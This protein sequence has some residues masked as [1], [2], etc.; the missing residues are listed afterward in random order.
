MASS[1]NIIMC[2]I[3]I[4]SRG[5][6]WSAGGPADP[7]LEGSQQPDVDPDNCAGAGV[8]GSIGKKCTSG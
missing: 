2:A 8:G 4:L 3:N 1:G 6:N 7:V 5:S